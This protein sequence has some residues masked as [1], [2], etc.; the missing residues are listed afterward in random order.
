[1]SIRPVT[2]EPGSAKEWMN[3]PMA[4]PGCPPG[5]EYLTQLDKIKVEQLVSLVEAFTG[6]ERNNKYALRNANNEQFFYAFEGNFISSIF[7]F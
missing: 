2:Q 6:F 3:R 4:I 7:I 1:M 5:L